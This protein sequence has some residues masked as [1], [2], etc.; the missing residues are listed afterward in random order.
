MCRFS[1]QQVALGR[2]PQGHNVSISRLS[3]VEVVAVRV[4]I[5]QGKV[6]LE[7]Q[8]EAVL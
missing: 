7:A 4:A 1:L 6:V 2:N 5:N 3:V 8:E